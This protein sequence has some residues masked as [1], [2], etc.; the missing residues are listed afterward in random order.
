MRGAEYRIRSIRLI[1]HPQLLVGEQQKWHLVERRR[2]REEGWTEIC[3]CPTRANA[4][5]MIGC[6]HQADKIAGLTECL[7]RLRRLH[8]DRANERRRSRHGE[9]SQS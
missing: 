1:V 4:Q 9:A 7:K 5:G 2:P 6:V 3:R 8:S